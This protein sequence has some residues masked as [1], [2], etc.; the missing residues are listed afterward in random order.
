MDRILD[1]S[2]LKGLSDTD[3]KK[4]IKNKA[5][6][7]LQK[8]CIGPLKTFAGPDIPYATISSGYQYMHRLCVPLTHS[9]S[10]K[11]EHKE[12]LTRLIQETENRV[13]Q[14]FALEASVMTSIA[15][16]VDPR[17]KINASIE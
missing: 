7:E 4:L 2:S 9:V 13:R 8:I 5:E 15:Q 12:T 10:A 6:T 16:R 1:E 3:V 14:H 11:E 17:L